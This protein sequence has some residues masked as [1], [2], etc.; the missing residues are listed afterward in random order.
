MLTRTVRGLHMNN[1][2]S[3]TAALM[4]VLETTLKRQR[5][6]GVPQIW[7]PRCSSVHRRRRQVVRGSVHRCAP[8]GVVAS[9]GKFIFSAK[10]LSRRTAGAEAEFVGRP[11]GDEDEDAE[12]QLREAR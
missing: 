8:P 2:I 12:E 4:Q 3:G 7:P 6:A 9:T 11:D 10:P 5:A 1:L